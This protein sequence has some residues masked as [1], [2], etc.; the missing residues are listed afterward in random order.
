MKLILALA[1]L[2]LTQAANAQ[3]VSKQK[4]GSYLIDTSVIG[5]G[6]KG[7]AGPTPVQIT[8]KKEKIVSVVPLANQESPKYFKMAT[9]GILP[10]YVGKTVK[11]A[12]QEQPD[13]VTGATRSSNAL[14]STIRRGL[15][16]Y[17]DN[18]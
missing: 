5:E 7:F 13:A 8:V 17:Q 18:K 12:L 4:D 15:R 14:K 9:D 6:I 16:E 10:K 3:W 2:S 1:L 11:Q